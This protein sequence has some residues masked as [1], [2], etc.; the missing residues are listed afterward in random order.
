MVIKEKLYFYLNTMHIVGYANN[1]FDI[2]IIM[3]KFKDRM[4][5]V[6]EES[7]K[8]PKSAPLAKHFLVFIF[9]SWEKKS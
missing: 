4:K 2:N 1:A 5:D 3:S 6:D 8:L 7:D 9:T